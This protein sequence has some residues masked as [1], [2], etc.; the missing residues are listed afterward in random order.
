MRYSLILKEVNRFIKQGR[1][2]LSIEE[3]VEAHSQFGS[4]L[5]SVSNWL[6]LQAPKSGL[7]EE[8][9]SI[10]TSVLLIGSRYYNDVA[11][12]NIFK[13]VVRKRIDWLEH[14]EMAPSEKSAARTKRSHPTLSG[15]PKKV[16]VHGPSG[17]LRNEV[18]NFLKKL[19]I[20]V[21]KSEPHKLSEQGLPDKDLDFSDVGFTVIL[22]SNSPKEI[23]DGL[24][25]KRTDDNSLM[26]AVFQLGFFIGK[27][28]TKRTCA[29]LET[30]TS[31]PLNSGIVLQ[32]EADAA[33]AWQIA[34]ARGMKRAGIPFDMNLVL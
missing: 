31:I 24:E 28:G 9:K 3:P 21:L 25:P 32:I 4:W 1:E 34:L 8:W 29:L 27:V 23:G 13:N 14:V 15:R 7:A 2:L 26:T 22:F 10:G 16:H 30:G 18:L 17:K 6:S 33:G 5:S 11:S 20:P 19:Q 12:W